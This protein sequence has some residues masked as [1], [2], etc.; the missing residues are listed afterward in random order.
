MF[1][2]LGHNFRQA[3]IMSVHTHMHKHVHTC[4]HTQT[5]TYTHS[6]AYYL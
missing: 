4:M 3:E 6:N 5:H 2:L 1:P